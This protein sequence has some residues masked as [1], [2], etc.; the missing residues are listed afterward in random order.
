MSLS[1]K[2]GFLPILVID[3]LANQRVALAKVALLAQ[4]IVL[5]YQAMPPC[6][7][8][9]DVPAHVACKLSWRRRASSHL[10]LRLRFARA[11]CRGSRRASVPLVVANLNSSQLSRGALGVIGWPPASG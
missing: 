4:V 5:A 9:R 3:G 11:G 10:L 2:V 8:D 6:A 7:N 1:I